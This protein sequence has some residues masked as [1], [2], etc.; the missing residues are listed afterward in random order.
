MIAVQF[1]RIEL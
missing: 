1:R